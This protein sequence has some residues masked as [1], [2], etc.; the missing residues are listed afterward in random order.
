MFEEFLKN[1]FAFL[2]DGVIVISAVVGV[3]C[4]KKYKKTTARF[5]V[6]FLIGA[7][8]VDFFGKYPSYFAKVEGFKPLFFL[9]K[10]TVFINNYWWYT[11]FW[12][13]GTSLFF[14]YYFRRILIN[15]RF[16]QILKYASVLLV[17]VSL[18]YLF[19]DWRFFMG[20]FVIPIIILNF[21]IIILSSS[22]YLIELLNSEQ[23]LSFYKSLNFY[24]AIVILIWWL[25]TTPL[26]FYDMY[27]NTSDWNYILLKVKIILLSNI[28]MYLTFTFA[29]IWCKPQNN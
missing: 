10:D 14:S 16:T 11:I 29:L 28:F 6:Y 17:V 25:I 24:I 22:F 1:N 27:M 2:N 9:I 7:A 26:A 3:L 8:L 13:I 18:C 5:F 21:I 23:I 12:T 15:K 19:L 4:F 20:S